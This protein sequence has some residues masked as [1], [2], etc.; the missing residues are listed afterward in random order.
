MEGK[1]ESEYIAALCEIVGWNRRLRFG[2]ALETLPELKMDGAKHDRCK[3]FT[4]PWP[5]EN[6][7]GPTLLCT[8][9]PT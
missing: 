2:D 6:Y 3:A 1:T 8:S 9:S 4:A 7:I 5:N